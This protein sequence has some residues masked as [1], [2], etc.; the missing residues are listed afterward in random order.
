MD[1]S[2]RKGRI[3]LDFP[4]RKLKVALL[5]E[6]DGET[7]QKGFLSRLANLVLRDNNLLPR[8]DVS[9]DSDLL[10]IPLFILLKVLFP[11]YLY[12]SPP[13]YPSFTA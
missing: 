8:N 5:K 7:T 9:P 10:Y 13:A 1:A 12:Q 2:S 6:K 3:R 4:Y 11:Y